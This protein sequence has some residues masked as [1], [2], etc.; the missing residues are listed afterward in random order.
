MEPK[1]SLLS[2]QKPAFELSPEL[3]EYSSYLQILQK[4]GLGMRSGWNWLRIVY[5]SP[6]LS[7]C[8]TREIL[9]CV[10]CITLQNSNDI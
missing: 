2:L 1:D 5:S 7:N 9:G 4:Q 8:T 6:E 10:L 3:H